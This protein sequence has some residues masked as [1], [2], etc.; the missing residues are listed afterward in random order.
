VIYLAPILADGTET[1]IVQGEAITVESAHAEGVSLEIASDTTVNVPQGAREAIS[2]VEIVKER[3]TVDTPSFAEP[4]TVYALEPSGT[5]LSKPSP[6]RLPNV[7]NFPPGMPVEIMSKNSATGKWDVGGVASVSDDGLWIETEEGGGIKHFSEVYAAPL[8][9]KI[10]Q[11]GAQDKP[12]ADSFNGALTTSISLPSYKSLSQDIAPGLIYNSQWAKPTTAIKNLFTIPD[13]KV[14]VSLDGQSLEL[15]TYRATSWL[16]PEYITAEVETGTLHT[17]KMKFTGVPYNSVISFALD[18]STSQSGVQPYRAHY[19]IRLKHMTIVTQE[20]PK[21]LGHN[22]GTRTEL[23]RFST[24]F[25]VFPPDLTGNIHIQNKSNSSAGRGWKIKGEQAILNPESPRLMLEEADGSFSTYTVD[26]RISTIYNPG[27]KIN[28]VDFNHWP[29]LSLA[30]NYNIISTISFQDNLA[31]LNEKII[32]PMT[33]KFGHNIAI[34]GRGNGDYCSQ[35][36]DCYRQKVDFTYRRTPNAL[37]RMADGEFLLGDLSGH[38]FQT[39]TSLTLAGTYGTPP[40]FFSDMFPGYYPNDP[41]NTPRNYCNSSDDIDCVGESGLE[42]GMHFYTS[43]SLFRC[44]YSFTAFGDDMPQSWTGRSSW[45]FQRDTCGRQEYRKSSEG[46]YPNPDFADGPQGISKLND[47]RQM[48]RGPGNTILIADFGNN[49]IR[50][51]D[52]TT[53]ETTTLAG[54]GQ[55]IDHGDGNFATLAGIYHPAALATDEVGNL[56]VATESGRI[57]KIDSSG[58][59]TTIAGNGGN[60]GFETKIEDSSFFQPEGLVFDNINNL[61]YVADTGHHRI[62]KLDFTTGK[63]T[64]VGGTTSCEIDAINLIGDG[65]PALEAQICSPTTLGLDDQQNILVFEKARKRIRRI[66]FSGSEFGTIAYVP[67]Q[68]DNSQLVR[69]ADGSFL[70]TFRSGDKVN[71]RADGKAT[72]ILERVGRTW[73]FEYNDDGTLG[74]QID[75]VGSRINYVYSSGKLEKIID[76]ANRE[77][78]FYYSGNDLNQVVYPDGTAT[79]YGHNGDGLIT[80]ETNQR[81]FTTSYEF[82]DWKRLAKVIRP[83]NS[84]IVM[85]DST[86]ATMGNNY[87]SGASG[88][89]KKYGTGANDVADGI[90]DARQNTTTFVKDTAGYIQTV[91]D[92]EGQTTSIDR[93]SDGR[94]TRITR[95][96]ATY[97]AFV[98]DLRPGRVGD[99]LSKFDS[100]TGVLNKYE[101]TLQ[102]DLT[103][104]TRTDVENGERTVVENVFLN[105][106]LLLSTTNKLVTPNQTIGFDYNEFGLEIL[107]TDPQSGTL[108]K[109]YDAFGNVSRLVDQLGNETFMTRDAKGNA[110]EIRNAKN[111]KTKYEFD[112]FNRPLAA[113]SAKDERTEYTYLENGALHTIKDPAGKFVTYTYSKLD[114]LILKNDQLGLQTKLF[115]DG[116]SNITMEIDSAGHIKLYELDKLDRVVK[117]TLPDNIYELEYNSRSNLVLVRDQKTEYTFNYIHRDEGDLVSK[118]NFKGIGARTDLPAYEIRYTY[119]QYSNKTST[120]TPVGT[121]TYQ[122][123]SGNRL[124]KIINHKG[125]NFDLSYGTLNHI[126]SIKNPVVESVLSFDSSSFINSIVHK[127]RATAEILARH[128]YSRDSIGNKTEIRSLLGTQTISYDQNN[129]VT[130]NDHGELGFIESFN[131]DNIGNRTSDQNGTYQYDLT[132]QR[133]TEDARFTYIFDLNGNISSKISKA[134][135]NLIHQFIH[136]SE[137]QLTRYQEFDNNV[138]IKDAIY[139]Y[140][141]LGMRVEKQIIDYVNSA[142]SHTRRYLYDVQEI[143][144]EVNQ[145]NLILSVYTQST[146]NTDDTLAVDVTAA[147]VTAGLAQNIGTYYFLKD[148]LGSVTDIVNGPGQ[149]IQHHVYSTFGTLEKITDSFGAIITPILAPYFTFTNREFDEESGL[150]YYRARYYDSS[151]GRLLETDPNKGLLNDPITFNN[152]YIYAKNNP[153]NLTDPFGSS[154]WDKVKGAVKSVGDTYSKNKTVI[155]AALLIG[156]CIANPA[157]LAYVA[158]GAGIG[159]AVAFTGGVMNGMSFSDTMDFTLKGALAGG[160]F[161]AIAFYSPSTVWAV[162]GVSA[163]QGF[164]TSGNVLVNTTNFTSDAAIGLIAGKAAINIAGIPPSFEYLGY[165][166]TAYDTDK[167]VCG[168]KGKLRNSSLCEK[169]VA[170]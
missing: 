136:N 159:A 157:M 104:Q 153:I 132:K 143:F 145:E 7:N 35:I 74:A 53:H 127:D 13:K 126:T 24:L 84:E 133:L 57:R 146:V 37:L 78:R 113:I 50:R 131:Y 39:G 115:Y 1:P 8:G 63:A 120:T 51:L 140:S 109:Y 28:S 80:S 108:Q 33:G 55:T 121:F 100:S 70:R 5:T 155:L 4:D 6:L 160:I 90:K 29:E 75:P 77:T 156:L 59:I 85:S 2:I 141:A 158:W 40:T 36:E 89:L 12:G 110:Y 88:Q 26:N 22:I 82:N 91:V 161:G 45:A 87:T 162:G 47:I 65:K 10:A 130:Q 49:R 135:P 96:D 21:L 11:I 111:Q 25:S 164:F 147:G 60:Y 27:T 93:D 71:Y 154:A 142:K 105:N 123:D 43:C 18:L 56:Y 98:Y 19:E 128:D 124:K 32:P 72:S 149:F 20:P 125:E 30:Q 15:S 151:V 129:Q 48:I 150:Y 3:T 69:N 144:A 44:T 61:L 166:Y 101:Y 9:P 42:H 148:S 167:K 119:D 83:D 168:N 112:A 95:P 116:N 67:F 118:V 102:G 165:L 163:F 66:N 54:T 38:I 117:K 139:T 23:E 103:K 169:S 52:L 73:N 86:S 17:D 16:E 137:N 79:Q 64:A 122:H 31:V 94:P 81:G 97:V 58:R 107:R 134:N 41:R 106:G 76:P 92:A 68:K 34:C 14:S 170:E 46:Q 62:V 99:L 114:E 138:L 152:K